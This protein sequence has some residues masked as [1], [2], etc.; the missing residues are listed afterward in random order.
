M[1]TIL[2]FGMGW[3]H[4][5]FYLDGWNGLSLATSIWNAI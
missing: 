5:P 4:Q 1:K 2:S 3:N